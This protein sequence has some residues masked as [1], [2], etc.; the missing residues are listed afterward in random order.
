MGDSF[1]DI[2]SISFEIALLGAPR[3]SLAAPS[4]SIMRPIA[5]AGTSAAVASSSPWPSLN[6]APERGTDLP[7]QRELRK[8]A[9]ELVDLIE[10]SE[11][12]DKRS[13]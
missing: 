9:N 5:V 13:H 12:S 6:V 8:L 4:W 1:W 7:L 11:Q 2:L 3:I 10:R